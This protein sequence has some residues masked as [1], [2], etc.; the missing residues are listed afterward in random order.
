M[1]IL[2]GQASVSVLDGLASASLTLSAALGLSLNPALP[3]PKLLPG[4]PEQLE[5]PSIDITLLAAVSVG[6]H[7]TICWVVSISWDGSWQF[8]QSISTPS[9]TVNV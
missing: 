4:S 5:I 7:I 2:T 8:S 6:I 1:V 9:L 3:I